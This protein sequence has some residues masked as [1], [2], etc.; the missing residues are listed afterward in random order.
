MNRTGLTTR[1]QSNIRTEPSD[2]LPL[3]VRVGQRTSNTGDF[4]EPGGPGFESLSQKPLVV[5]H[6]Y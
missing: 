3:G 5:A 4:S 1:L 2:Q 6:Q